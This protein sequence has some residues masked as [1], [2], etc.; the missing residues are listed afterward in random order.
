[1]SEQSFQIIQRIVERLNLT[2]KRRSLIDMTFGLV[3][4]VGAIAGL[5]LIVTTIEAGLWLDTPI[6]QVDSGRY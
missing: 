2:A 6:R 3:L 5:W 1:M 4:F